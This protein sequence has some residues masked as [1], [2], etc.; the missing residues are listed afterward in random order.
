NA[1]E[2]SVGMFLVFGLV[3]TDRP[4]GDLSDDFGPSILSLFPQSRTAHIGLG[5]AYHLHFW[6][7]SRGD[8]FLLAY[9][10]ALEIENI[11][12]LR[13]TPDLQ[14]LEQA[15]EEYRRVLAIEPGNKYASNNLGVALAELH[16]SQEAED[17]LR[18]ALRLDSQDFV[19]FNLGLVLYQK[20]Q[21]GQQSETKAEAI[22]LW[23]MPT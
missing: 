17:V 21:N 1:F 6:D 19:L 20:Y 13:G 2:S 8:D 4:P 11:Q 9:P 15:V 22:T 18:E 7:S 10:G 16:R 14:M 12:L 23:P 3:D 5:V